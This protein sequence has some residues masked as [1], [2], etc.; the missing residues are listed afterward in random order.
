M[1]TLRFS[2]RVLRGLL[3]AV[4]AVVI[5]FEEWGWKPLAAALA[6]LGRL[7]P[8]AWVET[9]VQSLPPY[10]ALAVFLV[11]STLLFPLK[12]LALYLITAGYK[13]AAASLF[14]GAKVVGTAIVA[15]LFQLTQPQLMH[16]AWFKRAYGVVMP[17][18]EAL[19]IWV[20]ASWAWRF[21]HIVK[22][23]IK[24]AGAAALNQWRPALARTREAMRAVVSRI[25][26]RF[27]RG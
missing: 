24:K 6:A 25:R 23:R 22:A 11:P 13:L 15:R 18:K 7:K 3:Q 9:R 12:L 14:I 10:A 8:F 4:L 17:W 16:I 20:R 5:V 2:G 21:G 27:G 26:R 19:V 1:R